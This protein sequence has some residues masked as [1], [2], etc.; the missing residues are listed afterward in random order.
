MFQLLGRQGAT[1]LVS[2]WLL[3]GSEVGWDLQ[4][5]PGSNEKA[6]VSQVLTLNYQS[7]KEAER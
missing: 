7:P 1:D 6:T 4:G 2:Q 3:D 5:Y